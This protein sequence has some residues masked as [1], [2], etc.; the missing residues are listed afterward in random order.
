MQSSTRNWCRT[1]LEWNIAS[2]ASYE[3]HTEGGCTACLGTVTIDGKKVT[4]NPAWYVLAHSAKFVR[5]GAVR[6]ASS[7]TAELSDVA[8]R[9]TDGS[10]VLIVV[11]N[12]VERAV[13]SISFNG[14]SAEA[15]LGGGA[16]AT[17]VWR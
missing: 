7:E 8:F 10:Y 15:Q 13:F 5:P 14:I 16:A 9:N 1:V 11:N 12:S 17:Y 3:P 2:D 4:R 6:L